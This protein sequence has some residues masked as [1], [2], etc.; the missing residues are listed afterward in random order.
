MKLS[1]AGSAVPAA[2]TI[3]SS[4]WSRLIAL[5]LSLPSPPSLQALLQSCS[6]ASR[7]QRSQQK[8]SRSPTL[9]E[10]L[11]KVI[12]KKCQIELSQVSSLTLLSSSSG[13]FIQPSKSLDL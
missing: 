1:A 10:A 3:Q 4:T 5:N 8:D 6:E 7:E 11:F 9:L 12:N 13:I 2:G